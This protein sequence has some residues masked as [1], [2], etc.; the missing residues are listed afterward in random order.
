[1]Q[2]VI[3]ANKDKISDIQDLLGKLVEF[4]DGK[5]RMPQ[6]IGRV[7]DVWEKWDAESELTADQI[8]ARIVQLQQKL[9]E[10]EGGK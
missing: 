4:G 6:F 1:M 3:H 2:E 10:K 7:V 8:K 5:M 9:K